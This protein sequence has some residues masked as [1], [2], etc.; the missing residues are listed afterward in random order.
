MAREHL[1]PEKSFPRSPD[2][3][4][5]HGSVPPTSAS[6]GE[7]GPQRRVALCGLASEPFL[8]GTVCFVVGAE[9]LTDLHKPWP[10]GPN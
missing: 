10:A 8:T 5:S 1:A 2:G 4:H 3:A 6:P 9:D 7:P